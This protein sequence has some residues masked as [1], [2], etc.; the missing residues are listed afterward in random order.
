[1]SPHICLGL[2]AFRGSEVLQFEL[3]QLGLVIVVSDL[4][5]IFGQS[6]AGSPGE[7]GS[8]IVSTQDLDI[9]RPGHILGWNRLQREDKLTPPHI[10][11]TH[12]G[13]LHEEQ[14][15]TEKEL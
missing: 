15:K 8:L 2:A 14:S 6:D 12:T 11:H 7:S 10:D 5:P 3:G 13:H 1:M 9:L 4:Q